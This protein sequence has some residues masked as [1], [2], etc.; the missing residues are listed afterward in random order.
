MPRP[1]TPMESLMREILTPPILRKVERN[2]PSE[3]FNSIKWP[4]SSIWGDRRIR[5]GNEVMYV[6]VYVFVYLKYE[7]KAWK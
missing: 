4:N 3:Y 5:T 1:L 7:G 2:S 6:A